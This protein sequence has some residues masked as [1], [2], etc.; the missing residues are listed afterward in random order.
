MVPIIP[1]GYE[2][3]WQC[4]TC[5]VEK[6]DQSKLVGAMSL[7]LSLILLY[8]LVG[9]SSVIPQE[10]LTSMKLALV[11]FSLLFVYMGFIHERVMKKLRI[12]S[13]LDLPNRSEC[14]LCSGKLEGT[15]HL[16]CANC[17]ILAL[18]NSAP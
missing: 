17:G 16:K 7:I 18:E 9:Y 8:C 4:T 12:D 15:E 1:L 2:Y 11:F 5:E 10:W 3:D 13:I 6:N 14:A